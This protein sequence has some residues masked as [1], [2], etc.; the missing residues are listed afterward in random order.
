MEGGHFYVL[1]LQGVCYELLHTMS[2]DRYGHRAHRPHRRDRG[3]RA[4]GPYGGDREPGRKP[5]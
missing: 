1:S 2:V 3:Y 5:L 4:D